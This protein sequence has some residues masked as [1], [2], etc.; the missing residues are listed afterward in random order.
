MCDRVG[1]LARGRL[2]AEG[3]PGG[4]AKGVGTACG[5]R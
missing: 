3:P 1:V 2:V 5:S 4:A